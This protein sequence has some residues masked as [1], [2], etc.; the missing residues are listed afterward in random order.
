MQEYIERNLTEAVWQK[1]QHSPVV[2]VL[3]PRQCGK[4]TLAQHVIQPMTNSLYLDLERSSDRDKLTNPELFFE[5]NR[6]RL[7]CLDEIQ[8]VPELFLVLRSVV[9]RM[10]THGQFLLLGSASRDLIQQSSETLA[11][12]IAYLELTP[13][14]LNEVEQGASTDPLWKLFLKGGFPRSF[15]AEE[16]QSF[17]WRQD[18]IRTFL[19]R[20]LPQLGIKIPAKQLERFWKM[21]AHLHGQL[22]NSSKLGASL[23][24]SY[25]TVRSYVDLLEQTF[26]L[27]VLP[28]WEA[29]LKK[30]L[31]KSPKIYLRDSGLLHGLMEI[32]TLNDLLGH[33]VYGASW[34]GFVI[35]TILSSLPRWKGSFYRTAAGAEMDL[36][37]SWK[38]HRIALECKAASAPQ[39][40]SG[41][42]NALEDLEATQAWIVSPVK[43]AFPLKEK[44]QVTPLNH[45]LHYLK[46]VI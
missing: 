39:V 11:G 40:T 22:L 29:N 38:Q 12:R 14:L 30:R 45:L 10:E 19:E 9:D 28:P 23:G 18:F 36:I 15:L 24:V 16:A 44:V 20:D 7:I 31:V 46:T 3:G 17:E 21:C 8:R 26:I 6:G 13:F 2:A 37:L 43:E 4:S 34:E 33:P 41:F 35:E 25:H 27:R 5:I 32:E 42:W 1:L